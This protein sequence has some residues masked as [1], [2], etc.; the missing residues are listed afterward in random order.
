M[1]NPT[2]SCL[3]NVLSGLEMMEDSSNDVVMGA[4]GEGGYKAVTSAFSSG[5]AAASAMVLAHSQRPVYIIIPDDRYHGVPVQL[6]SVFEGRN[7]FYTSVDM[8]DVANIQKEVERILCNDDDG[9]G[10]GVGDGNINGGQ[11][12][13]LVWIET[14]SN[15]LCKVTDIKL[16][17]DWVTQFREAKLNGT[18]ECR[19]SNISTVVDSTWAPPVITQPLLLG[20]DAVL[21]SG[22]KYLGGHSDLLLGSITT[23]PLTSMGRHLATK[24]RNVQ[25]DLGATA[26]PFDSWLVLRGLRTLHVRIQRQCYNALAIAQFLNDHPIVTKVHYPGLK[27]HPQH[28]LAQRQMGGMYGG[29]LSFEVEGEAMAVAVAGGL[30]T[31]RR[32]T[33]LGG[34]ETLVEHRYS[35]EPEGGKTSPEG[36]LRLSVGLED[37][38][39]LVED[40]DVALGIAA[41]VCRQ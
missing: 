14:P 5:M 30:G 21:H 17:C 22:T 35:V 29:M 10:V 23:S 34:T 11:L 33:S 36:L 19:I 25:I 20:A 37:V 27:E 31:V 3:E 2:R 1:G 9:E 38:G 41:N 6:S 26:S 18:D 4:G 32:A 16:V 39:D 8:T 28:H 13:V 40:L 12:D 15:P 24:I 7:V